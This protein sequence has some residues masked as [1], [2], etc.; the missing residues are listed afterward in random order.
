[1]STSCWYHTHWAILTEVGCVFV[2][3]RA[4]TASQSCVSLLRSG[5]HLSL[6]K[7]LS[8][9]SC[10]TGGTLEPKCIAGIH[11]THRKS[12]LFFFFLAF[13]YRDIIDPKKTKQTAHHMSSIAAAYTFYILIGTFNKWKYVHL[14]RYSRAS[15][16]L[17][18]LSWLLRKFSEYH[19]SA[20]S[21][22]F[23]EHTLP[24]RSVTCFL[25]WRDSV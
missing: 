12:K 6:R 11:F 9:F 15:S 22:E 10:L 2:S 1:M 23:S 4:P 5:L 17:Q 18:K 19:F 16:Y 24:W 3:Q 25:S 21:L 8:H 20:V 14:Y 13:F 7:S